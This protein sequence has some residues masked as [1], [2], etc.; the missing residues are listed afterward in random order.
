MRENVP[1]VTDKTNLE[2]DYNRNFLRLEVLP[3]V[4]ERFPKMEDSVYKLSV[5]AEEDDDALCDLA[6]NYV[7]EKNGATILTMPKSKALFARACIDAMK[8]AGIKK[9]YEKKH[10]DALYDLF[11][12]SENGTSLSLPYGVTATLEYGK[13]SF[14]KKKKRDEKFIPFKVGYFE[15]ETCALRIEKAKGGDFKK[16][17]GVHFIDA[18]KVPLGAVIRTRLIGDSFK[19]FAEN[20]KKLKDYLIDKKIPKRLRDELLLIANGKD[21]LYVG[22][23][24]ISCKVKIDDSTKTLYKLTFFTEN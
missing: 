23:E 4:K 1:F 21:I 24:E 17:D 8:R 14:Y 11:I 20:T 7:E 22:G 13:I 10:I 6:K 15:T 12:S 5:L 19:T 9:D 2:P 16:Q 3:K 18:D